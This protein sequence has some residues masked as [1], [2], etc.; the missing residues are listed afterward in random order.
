MYIVHSLFLWQI[1]RSAGPVPP[2]PAGVPA[3]PAELAPPG[4]E[5]EGNH[6]PRL[7]RHVLRSD[8]LHQ[9]T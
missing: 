4:R 3:A 7:P 9:G 8:T 5:E 6:L 2:E 1:W